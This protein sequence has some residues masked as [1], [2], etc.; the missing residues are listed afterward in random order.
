M[1]NEVFMLHADGSHLYTWDK[2]SHSKNKNIYDYKY[3]YTYIDWDVGGLRACGC[4]D[5]CLCVVGGERETEIHLCY[6]SF[7]LQGGLEWPSLWYTPRVALYLENKSPIKPTI[8]WDKT[9]QILTNTKR[10]EP[11]EEEL[12]AGFHNM[13]TF[14]VSASVCHR[15]SLRD[16]LECAGVAVSWRE[17]LSLLKLL[18]HPQAS[19]SQS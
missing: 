13:L 3:T 5:M 17:I 6:G 18:Q 19:R 9:R 11:P 7:G 4:A 16:L 1:L 14:C 15:V 10:F 8:G 12:C 2:H